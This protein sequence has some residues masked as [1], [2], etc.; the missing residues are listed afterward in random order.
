MIHVRRQWPGFPGGSVTKS[1]SADAETG[2]I[3]D[4]EDPHR[5][6]LSLGATAVEPVL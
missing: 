4:P 3:P 6:P 2:S 5:S 1:P